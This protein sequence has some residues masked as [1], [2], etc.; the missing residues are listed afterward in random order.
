MKGLQLRDR[1][2]NE[3]LKIL[4]WMIRKVGR[5]TLIESS[6]R[7]WS[8][9]YHI[10]SSGA[11]APLNWSKNEGNPFRNTVEDR[12]KGEKVDKMKRSWLF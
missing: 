10:L 3:I 4:K 5:K 9:N 2:L 12:Y 7:K 8:S 6:L 1:L 11:L